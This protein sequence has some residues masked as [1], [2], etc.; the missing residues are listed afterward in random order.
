MFNVKERKKEI[1]LAAVACVVAVAASVLTVRFSPACET[2]I[3]KDGFEYFVKSRDITV[4]G[5]DRNWDYKDDTLSIE[6]IDCMPVT[7]IYLTAGFLYR[8]NNDDI[9]LPNL[10]TKLSIPD[11]VQEIALEDLYA[12]ESINIPDG[13]T[14][15][16]LSNC[17]SLKNI[18]LPDGVT[19]LNLKNCESLTSIDIPDGVTDISLAGCK[20]LTSVIIPYSVTTISYDSFE[21]CSSLTSI[22]IPD[23]VTDISHGAFEGCSSLTSIIIPDSVTYLDDAFEGCDSLVSVSV[24]SGLKISGDYSWKDK[25]VYR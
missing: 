22:I 23:S 11:N 13:V 7:S 5:F 17:K 20:S 4:N 21:G 25:V 16:K 15:L 2:F 12:L 14:R 18:D 9:D 19:V 10:I 6:N 8:D 1:V 3:Y 24:P